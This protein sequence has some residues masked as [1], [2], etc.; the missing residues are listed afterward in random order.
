M[1]ALLKAPRW[2]AG[3]AFAAL[4]AAIVAVLEVYAPDGQEAVHS[5]EQVLWSPVL[6]GAVVGALQ[7]QL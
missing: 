7:V 6:C 2:V 5:F 3:G 4:L 1:H